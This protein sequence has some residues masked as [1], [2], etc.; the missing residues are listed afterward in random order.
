MTPPSKPDT[1][2]PWCGP[3]IRLAIQ[4][5]KLIP[6]KNRTSNQSS[7]GRTA[8]RGPN[9]PDGRSGRMMH[10]RAANRALARRAESSIR[11]ARCNLLFSSRTAVAATTALANAT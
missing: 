5:A 6:E 4:P 2:A 3:T 1:I 9:G 10:A 11:V 8:P 7:L